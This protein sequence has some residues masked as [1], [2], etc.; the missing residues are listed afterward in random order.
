MV[1]VVVMS[2]KTTIIHK[3]VS[4]HNDKY[5]TDNPVETFYVR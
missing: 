4:P 1:F 3:T 2:T 5:V